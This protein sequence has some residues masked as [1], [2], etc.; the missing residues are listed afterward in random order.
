[1]S[2]CIP[3]ESRH[4][5][6]RPR[7]RQTK[8]GHIAGTTSNLPKRRI[9]FHGTSSIC[10]LPWVAALS[11]WMMPI[12]PP[13][14]YHRVASAGEENPSTRPAG[15]VATHLVPHFAS[16]FVAVAISLIERPRTKRRAWTLPAKSSAWPLSSRH[17]SRMDLRMGLS[18]RCKA[19]SPYVCWL[20]I[21]VQTGSVSR[22]NVSSFDLGRDTS[23]LLQKSTHPHPHHT[24]PHHTT[25][26]TPHHI[27]IHTTPRSVSSGA[28]V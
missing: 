14:Q 26:H 11:S 25:P 16:L 28:L 12:P 15:G 3:L 9:S 27:H 17:A 18:R 13:P 4:L 19:D 10:L 21:R 1:M 22:T 6:V 8:K 7:R 2:S 5:T 23:G 20:A 24:T